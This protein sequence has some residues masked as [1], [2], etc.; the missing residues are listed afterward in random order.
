VDA[1][2]P[3][4]LAE[5][6]RAILRSVAGAL[7]PGGILVYSTC[8]L[9]PE[10]NEAVVEGFLRENQGVAL[11]PRETAAEEVRELLDANG[12]LR[13]LPHRHDTDGFFAA[14]FE[15]RP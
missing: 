2:D 15:R 9:L 1:R 5:T 14:R 13:T 4:R 11:A 6:Q 10:E 8:T 3:A 7:R 12:F